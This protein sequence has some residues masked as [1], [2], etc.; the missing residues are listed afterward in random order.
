MSTPVKFSIYIVIAVVICAVVLS[1]TVKTQVTPE[2]VRKTLLPILEKTLDRKVDFGEISIGLFTGIVVSDLSVKQKNAKDIFF[3]VESVELHYR[4]L[5][6]LLGDIIFDRV[7]FDRP[8]ISCI[9]LAENQYNFSDLLPTNSPGSDIKTSL[10]KSKISGV[11]SSTFNLLIKEIIINDG[12]LQFIDKLKNPTSPFR[13][14]LNNLNIKARQ[15]AFDKSF[16][17]DFS[18]I[19]NGANID[20]SGRYDLSQ[21]VGD[22]TIHLAPLDVLPFAPYYR[23]SFPGKIGS[24]NLAL[25]LEVDLQPHLISSKGMI[26]FDDVDLVFR[27][28]PDA[29][30][31]NTSFT[32]DYAVNYDVAKQY[33]DVST[34]LLNFNGI[35]LGAEGN[36]T[37]STTDPFLVFTLYL[38]KIDLRE[39]MQSIPADLTRKYQKY[40]FA[41]LVDGQI[42][43]RGNLSSGTQLLKSGNLHLSDIRASTENF[44]AGVSGDIVYENNL[45]QTQNLKLQYGD[46]QA[47]L[48]FKGATLPEGIFQG[49]FILTADA[50]DIEKLL[51]SQKNGEKE[52]DVN[53]PPV[54][55]QRTL[56]EDIGPFNVP[57]NIN[58]DVA[59]NRLLYNNLQ[60]DKMTARMS[61]KDNYLV[62][63][64]LDGQLAEGQL[65]GSAVINLAVQGLAYQGG[66]TVN[67]SKA[68]P[69]ITGLFPSFEK[70]ISG[71]VQIQNTFSGRGTKFENFLRHLNLNGKFS[72][73]NGE[74]SGA[75]LQDELADFL[76]SPDL[77]TLSFESLT[78]QYD[79]KN[80]TAHFNSRLDS[81]TAKVNPV[82]TMKSDGQVDLSLDI[83]VAPEI[84]EKI[85]VNSHLKNTILDANGWGNL[86][87]LVQGSL[88]H[89]Q[90][91]YDSVA[92]QNRLAKKV[93][94]K[95]VEEVAPAH[96]EDKESVKKMLDNTLN[97]LFGK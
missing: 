68:M 57:V 51:I 39:V 69:L 26:V 72:L 36:A 31:K 18:A 82:G 19:V 89:P 49:D 7:Y 22:L 9:R 92:L 13:Y 5:S 34:L 67:Q 6:L 77:K 43:L 35:N 52:F 94:Q 83:S 17:V 50:L 44:R 55:R 10:I 74:V 88:T 45:L 86:P 65:K 70:N 96:Q 14:T 20:I 87:L 81:S 33:L 79:F 15:I 37:H 8:V 40:S 85:K 64:N 29:A 2:K 1:V 4:F 3:T 56:S 73:I 59:I 84:L 80:G 38:K 60:F 63:N 47:M 66:M 97:K 90:F 11:L 53:D 25:K 93:S 91:S 62:I 46:Q 21:R 28:Q 24:G 61:L 54:Q 76:G 30:L 32:V 78:G 12:T 48:Q 75:S 71:V 41:G 58:G 16:P 23:D 42:D 27:N 95:L